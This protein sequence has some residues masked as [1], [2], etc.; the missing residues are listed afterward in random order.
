MER[1]VRYWQNLTQTGVR[2]QMEAGLKRQIVLANYLALSLMPVVLMLVL[3][4]LGLR[5][6]PFKSLAISSFLVLLIAVF[7]LNKLGKHALSRL[8]FSI[9]APIFVLLIVLVSK[10][11]ADMSIPQITS[12][13]GDRVFLLLSFLLPLLLID[14]QEEPYTFWGVVQLDILALAG[15]DPLHSLAGLDIYHMELGPLLEGYHIANYSFLL[16][17]LAII[18]SVVFLR[19]LTTKYQEQLMSSNEQLTATNAEI[20]LRNQELK[21]Q[22]EEIFAQKESIDQQVELVQYQTQQINQS[23]AAA[24]QIQQSTLPE[25]DELAQIL[26]PSYFVLNRPKE[27]VSGDFHWCGQCGNKKVIMVGDCT[28]HG[29][30]GAFMTLI[31]NTLLDQ[32]VIQHR[33]T[34]PATILEELDNGIRATLKQDQTGNVSGLEGTVLSW[35]QPDQLTFAAAKS[36]FHWVGQQLPSEAESTAFYK[37]APKMSVTEVKGTRRAIGGTAS[38]SRQFDNHQVR[39]QAGSWV[40]LY[41]DGFVDQNDPARTRFG[42]NSF[43]N[44]LKMLSM[45][46]PGAQAETAAAILDQ[47]MSGTEQRDDILLIGFQIA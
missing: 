10:A 29:V 43:Q 40:Y 8:L 14:F 17:G 20:A 39:L 2:P 16:C 22:K 36:S 3:M 27:V 42:K 30:A 32:I 34:D 1:L 44:M 25:S 9:G 5:W 45:L 28:G 12:Y 21:Q 4:E 26:G 7:V 6:H 37:P 19:S 11:S 38:I 47:H 46:D 13:Y 23:I 18:L 35:E 15:Y 41:T 24:S 33:I 31:A